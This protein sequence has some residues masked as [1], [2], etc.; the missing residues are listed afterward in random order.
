MPKPMSKQSVSMQRPDAV[1]HKRSLA[2]DSEEVDVVRNAHERARSALAY[3][4][5]PGDKAL[6]V[7]GRQAVSVRHRAERGLGTVPHRR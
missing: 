3:R 4:R 2:Q 6:N 5:E 1:R 7:P